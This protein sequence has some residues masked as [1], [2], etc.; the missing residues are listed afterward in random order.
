MSPPSPQSV[1]E[2]LH[3]D[4]DGLLGALLPRARLDEDKE[5]AETAHTR[6]MSAVSHVIC[7]GYYVIMQE[8]MY[9]KIVLYTSSLLIIAGAYLMM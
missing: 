1:P 2:V 6:S 9:S 7:G 8:E 5:G 3:V 4:A